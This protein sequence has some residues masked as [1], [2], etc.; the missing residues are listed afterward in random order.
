M[1]F[2]LEDDVSRWNTPSPGA[3][4]DESNDNWTLVIPEAYDPFVDIDGTNT[5]EHLQKPSTSCCCA[6]REQALDEREKYLLELESVFAERVEQLGERRRMLDENEGA[7]VAAEGHFT[8]QDELMRL[9]LADAFSS[10]RNGRLQWSK[11]EPLLLDPAVVVA[12]EHEHIVRRQLAD[13][14][15][16][17]Y[18][19]I[20]DRELTEGRL[21]AMTNRL[22]PDPTLPSCSA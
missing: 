7:I 9:A 22:N 12:V 2:L 1:S 15:A 10:P 6:E 16:N 20:T 14:L 18:S 13:E 5:E 3:F 8:T 4:N 21:D 17:Y 19:S 11:S